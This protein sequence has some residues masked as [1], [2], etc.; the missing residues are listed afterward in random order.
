MSAVP[1]PGT[2]SRLALGALA[3]NQAVIGVWA[4]R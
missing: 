3:A 2:W 1:R 4:S